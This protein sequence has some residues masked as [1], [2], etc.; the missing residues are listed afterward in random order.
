MAQTATEVR[1]TRIKGRETIEPEDR[2]G[3]LQMNKTNKL[4]TTRKHC[5]C[6]VLRR[7][8]KKM[9]EHHTPMT[10]SAA[11]PM[12]ID[13]A[14]RARSATE[15]ISPRCSASSSTYSRPKPTRRRTLCSCS[16][17]RTALFRRWRC[18]R[19]VRRFGKCRGG[20]RRFDWPTWPTSGP[21]RRENGHHEPETGGD[22]P[23]EGN[24][25]KTSRDKDEQ[26]A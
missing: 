18:P 16:S 13:E 6:F 8:W 19:R 7:A 21:R 17:T 23:Q 20:R 22:E 2:A 24:Q 5:V 4:R 14:E 1:T 10:L 11:Q 25:K 9:P 26:L 15:T 3:H 12:A